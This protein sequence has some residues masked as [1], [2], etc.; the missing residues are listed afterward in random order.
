MELNGEAIKRNINTGNIWNETGHKSQ[1][2]Q[3]S[4][5]KLRQLG[6]SKDGL[7]FV[8]TLKDLR[9]MPP[10]IIIATATTAVHFVQNWSKKQ[11][12]KKNNKYVM[13][14]GVFQQLQYDF[15]SNK[16]LLK[17]STM[18]FSKF[19]NPYRGQDLTD[20]TLL[21]FRTGGIGD[22]LFIKPNLDYLKKKYPTC[23]IKFACGPQY[24]P[25]V[26]TWSCVD[27]L[28][29]LPFALKHLIECDYHALFE[30]VIERCKES[31]VK[32]SY[33]LFS[34]WMGLNLPDEE[35]IPTQEAKPELIENCKEVLKGWG[36]E[37]GDFILA[38]LRASSP[39]RTP[40]H[41]FWLDLFN[42]LID[43]G[44]NIILTDNPRQTKSVDDFIKLVDKPDKIFN[45]CQHSESL[46]HSI[47]L[48]SLAGMTLCTDSAFSHIGV[49]VGTPAMGIFGPFPGFV[50]MKTYPNADWVDAER[51]CAPCFL[52]G[53]ESCP[54][55]AA[56]GY[57][58]CYDE[59]DKDEVI[60]R[61]EKLLNKEKETS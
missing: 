33:N 9:K 29:D 31:Y 59:I 44:Y 14:L 56:D 40:N 61:I 17:P 30:G 60:E 57:S 47:A 6:L 19:Y 55:A 4:K 43:K 24:Q 1:A 15:N 32:N 35:L 39:I 2:K 34:E 3:V 49:S 42:K 37:K 21:I 45:F 20:S 27:E 41:Q 23:K 5:T 38:Q 52:H 12:L 54:Q 28:L 46:D 22:L 13:G 50:R 36:V 25:M 53:Q 58:P 11:F 10:N 48:T 8:E 16:K 26:E 51:S 7:N 18:K